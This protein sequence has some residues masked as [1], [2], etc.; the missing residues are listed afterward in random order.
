MRSGT[1]DEL[2]ELE[3]ECRAQEQ[4]QLLCSLPRRKSHSASQV[5][6]LPD[7]L[8]YSPGL[9]SMQEEEGGVMEVAAGHGGSSGNHVLTRCSTFS[10]A[11]RTPGLE[12]F[13]RGSSM[14]ATQA[15]ATSREHHKVAGRVYLSHKSGS[16]SMLY[17]RSFTLSSTF[18]RHSFKVPITGRVGSVSAGQHSSSMLEHRGG[19]GLGQEPAEHG[20]R[21]RRSLTPPASPSL[22][23]ASKSLQS[24]P[25]SLPHQ[26]LPRS[27]NVSGAAFV[28]LFRRPPGRSAS[29]IPQVRVP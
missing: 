6:G 23:S 14:S 26:Q 19:L 17:D 20:I 29:A 2:M 11:N 9:R 15:L 16:S 27:A 13:E 10:G 18:G 8:Q 25:Q 28:K 21:M 12:G 22:T 1:H 24:Q 3:A 5:H 7:A 4:Q